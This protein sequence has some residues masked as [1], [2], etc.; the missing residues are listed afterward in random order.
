MARMKVEDVIKRSTLANARKDE[1]RAIYQE[2]YEYALP[3]RNLYDGNYE[4]GTPGQNKMQKV[5]DSTAI[6]STQRFAN[7]IQSGLFP[8]YRVWCRLQAGTAIPT[9][10]TSEVQ[11]ILDNY[12]ERMFNI[13]RQTNFDLAMSEFLLDLAVGTAVMLIQPGDETAPIRFTPVPQYL[14][15]LEEGP[16]GS[17]D[18][19][20]RKLRIKGEVIDRQWTDAKIPAML[21]DQ[22]QRKPTDEISLLEATVYNKDLGMYCYHVIHEKSKEELVYRTMKISPWIVARFMK[23]SG[24][25]YGRGPLLSAM[26]DIKTLNKV[27]ELV[28]KNASLAIAGVY[29][30]A[31]DGVLNP[32]TIR[33]QPGAIIPVARNGGPTGPSLMP[34][35]KSADFSV[36]SIIIPDLRMNIKKTLLD[37]SLPPD[38]M[39]ARSATEIVQRMKELSQNLGSAFG[40]LITEAMIPIINRVLFIMDDQGLI[41]MPLKVNGQEVKVVPISPLAQAQNMDE[42]NDVLQFMQVVG[43][44]GPEAQLALKKDAVIDFIANRLGVPTSLLT[45]PEERQMMMQQMQQLAQQAQA[46]QQGQAPEQ[47]MPPQG[48]M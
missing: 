39:S 14:V 1:W 29:T 10:R 2:C 16:H 28:L 13:M 32:Q 8:P 34:L 33:I 5:Y 27:L 35:P 25:V 4:G 15:A 44:M 19:V 26:P 3:Q 40:R 45:S 23:V 47:G 9:E 30:A 43:G 11:I 38:N 36:S 21:K 12:T 17:V 24:E 48:A 37:D 22:I 18:N 7:R 6:D 41:D 42:V 31:D 20:Y 46:M